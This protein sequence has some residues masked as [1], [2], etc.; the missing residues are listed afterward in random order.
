MH[1][2]IALKK[3]YISILGPTS[4][5]AIYGYDRGL[6]IH[7]N[8]HCSPCDDTIGCELNSDCLNIITVDEILLEIE[9]M[10]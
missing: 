6:F 4:V 1:V 7:S 3:K 2:A 10:I 8:F 5:N 9:N